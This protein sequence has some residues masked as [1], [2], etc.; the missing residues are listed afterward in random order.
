MGDGIAQVFFQLAPFLG[1]AVQ[2]GGIEMIAPAPTIL[3]GIE[4]QVGIAISA[5]LVTPSSGAMAMP[6]EAPIIT[7][8]PSIA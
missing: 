4:R 2:V 3:G 7:R 8:L 5:S 1:I 6:T